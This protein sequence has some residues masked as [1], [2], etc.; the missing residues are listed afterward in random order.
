MARIHCFEKFTPL[1]PPPSPGLYHWG[2]RLEGW[3]N[4]AARLA[5]WRRVTQQGV[6][7]YMIE[8]PC[9]QPWRTTPLVVP[10]L[11]WSITKCTGKP[12]WATS[13][14]E[15]VTDTLVDPCI[16]SGLYS[17]WGPLGGR[18]G[19]GRVGGQGG[20]RLGKVIRI[21]PAQPRL[22]T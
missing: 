7:L 2:W 22:A 16:L 6:I 1:F 5:G 20:R 13:R 14:K 15:G 3:T 18:R 21:Q 17:I 10:V 12:S 8:G 19:G 9:H 11:G 4:T